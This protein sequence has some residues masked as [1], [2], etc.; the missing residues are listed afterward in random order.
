VKYHALISSIGY[1]V[2]DNMWCTFCYFWN[3]LDAKVYAGQKIHP[4]FS[5]GRRKMN[6]I[7]ELYLLRRK[8][9]DIVVLFV[10]L[11]MFKY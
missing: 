10:Y 8:E 4:F 9:K 6:D 7:D 5:Y 2:V 3:Q 1:A 11:K